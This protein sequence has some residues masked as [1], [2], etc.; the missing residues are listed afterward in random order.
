[1][2]VSISILWCWVLLF[3]FVFL[4]I[5]LLLNFLYGLQLL[6]DPLDPIIDLGKPGKDHSRKLQKIPPFQHTLNPPS[7]NPN[8]P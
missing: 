4:S 7:F 8:H 1:M 5:V 3:I 6:N 2:E